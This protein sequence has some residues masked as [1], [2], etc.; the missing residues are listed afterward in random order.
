MIGAELVFALQKEVRE[1]CCTPLGQLH[2]LTTSQ[3]PPTPP[4]G[5]AGGGMGG[6][7]GVEEG[8]ASEWMAR[9]PMLGSYAG[10]G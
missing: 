9:V 6:I 5:E 2:H 10:R 1:I 3:S 8:G 7:S 4:L